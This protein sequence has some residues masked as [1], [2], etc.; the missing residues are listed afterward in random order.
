MFISRKGVKFF[1]LLNKIN[2]YLKF[3]KKLVKLRNYKFVSVGEKEAGEIWT[4][5]FIIPVIRVSRSQVC[6]ICLLDGP[7][8]AWAPGS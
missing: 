1:P 2:K 5:N 6:F 7:S 4:N 8:G 3:L